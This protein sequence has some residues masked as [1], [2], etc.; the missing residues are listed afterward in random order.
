MA[1]IMIIDGYFAIRE[2]LMEELAS[3]G[4]IVTAVGEKKSLREKI[5]IMEPDRPI[6]YGYLYKRAG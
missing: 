3:E 1:N 4:H 2:L 5:S 6:D